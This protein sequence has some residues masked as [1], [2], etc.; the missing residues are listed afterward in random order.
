[1]R[2][3]GRA[4]Y[5]FVA[6]PESATIDRAASV[7]SVNTRRRAVGSLT[8][9]FP[10]ASAN[11]PDTVAKDL[12]ETATGAARRRTGG[13]SLDCAA[14]CSIATQAPRTPTRARMDVG[15]EGGLARL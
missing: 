3:P 9:S 14:A 2:P 5:S 13:N 6:A 15:I 12:P 1:M 11:T 4:P 8:S 10:A 7:V